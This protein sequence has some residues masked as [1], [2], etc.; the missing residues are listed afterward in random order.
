MNDPNGFYKI[1]DLNSNAT[2]DEIK[3]KY[4]KL[5][6][7]YHPDKNDG[8]DEMFKNLNNAYEVL[9]DPEKRKEYDNP[10]GGQIPNNLNDIFQNIFNANGFNMGSGGP[11]IQIFRNGV[12]VNVQEQMSKPPPIIQNIQ[13]S[14]E[15]SFFGVKIP[16]KIERWIIM[17]NQKQIEKETL[18]VELPKGID[19]GEIIIIKDK[20]NKITENNC[21]DLKLIIQVKNETE[22]KREGLNLF[23]RKQLTLKEALCGFEFII[24]HINGNQYSINN[25]GEQV[26]QPNTKKVIQKLG[27]E[28]DNHIGDLVIIFDVDFPNQLTKEQI[29]EISNIL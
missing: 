26:I 22:F 8:K 20:G 28:R 23:F 12:R 21:S 3:K 2:Q 6:M 5:S 15:Q 29:K 10:L 18:Y 17:N 11:N 16:L 9:G 14:L 13:I 1:L 4:R 24:K 27:I 25:G 19:S 7:K